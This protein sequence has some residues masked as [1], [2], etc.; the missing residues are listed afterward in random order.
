[1]KTLLSLI[2]LLFIPFQESPPQIQKVNIQIHGLVCSLCTKSV[3]ESVSKLDFVDQVQANLAL[4]QAEVT[5]KSNAKISFYQLARAVERAGFSVGGLVVY[6]ESTSQ[7]LPPKGILKS[8]EGFIFQNVGEEIL[9]NDGILALQLV[10][11]DFME[12]K[13][14]KKNWGKYAYKGK[15]SVEN[16]FMV[17][18]PRRP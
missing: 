12:K 3:E 16:T 1:M 5:F 2:F 7:P 9:G 17:A 10:G 4:T 13:E 18:A 11:V 14:F 8:T 6:L 15:N